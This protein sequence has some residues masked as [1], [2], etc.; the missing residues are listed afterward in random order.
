MTKAQAA[1]VARFLTDILTDDTDEAESLELSHLE[2]RAK[3]ESGSEW[4]I[5]TDCYDRDDD[6]WVHRTFITVVDAAGDVTE[7]YESN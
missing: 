3:D 1:T 6:E 2:L 5:Q 4:V 7:S